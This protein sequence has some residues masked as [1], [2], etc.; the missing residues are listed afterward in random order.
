MAERA[1]LS[2]PQPLE[3]NEWPHHEVT[4]AA[5]PVRLLSQEDRR[6]EA[7]NYLSSGYGLRLAVES[8]PKG[9]LKFSSLAHV[10]QPSRL[11][12]ILVSPKHGTPYLAATQIFDLRPTPRK[13]LALERT[14]HSDKLFVER[15]K[16]LVTRSGAVGKATLAYAPYL[17]TLISD[18]LLRVE[19]REAK[20]YGWIYAFLRSNQALAMMTGAKYG[21]VI[22]HLECSHLNSVPIP[23]PSDKRLE[24]FNTTVESILEKRE[25][26]SSLVIEAE[27]LFSEAVGKISASGNPEVGFEVSSAVLLG[28]R[29]RLEGS[30]HTTQA[31]E[32][33]NH[34]RRR[35]FPVMPL[36]EVT[37]RVWW[38]T[39]F[40]RVFGDE[41]VPY[42]SAEELF[43]NNPQ[44]TKRVLIE[45]AENAKEFF[46]KA[47]WIIMACSGQ[48][49][50]LLGSVAL[51]TKYNEQAFFSHDLVRI[52]PRREEIHPGYLMTAL[53]HPT[54]GRPL[55]IRY[56]YGTSIPH[57]EPA[58]VSTFPVV[59]LG[60]STERAIGERVEKASTLRGEADEL[61]NAITAEAEKLIEGFVAGKRSS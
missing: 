41:G 42:F 49:Y 3:R 33:L 40:K 1:R 58:D 53:G 16:I 9:W 60:D 54:L 39:R 61:E 31:T 28:K 10:W 48:T 51:M 55:V 24:Y 43:I 15:G 6:M 35:K 2:A 56:A 22:K 14:Q 5:L 36:A 52:I 23:V 4:W 45:Q 59:R 25:S 17:N 13:W 29:R 44:I 12:G 8:Q 27:K 38:M 50:G 19:P 57:L 20:S 26:A 30:Y 32:I 18:D 21:H 47:G 11:K 7:E 46:V 34:F 37:R